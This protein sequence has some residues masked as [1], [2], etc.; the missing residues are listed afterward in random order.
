MTASFLLAAAAVSAAVLLIAPPMDVDAQAAPSSTV[1]LTRLPGDHAQP[2]A[3][4]ISIGT[5]PQSLNVIFTSAYASSWVTAKE[6]NGCARSTGY[7][8]NASSTHT[9]GTTTKRFDAEEMMEGLGHLQGVIAVDTVTIGGATDAAFPFTMVVNSTIPLDRYTAADGQLSLLMPKNY[10]LDTPE[11]IVPFLDHLKGGPTKYSLAFA[12]DLSSGNLTLNPTTAASNWI[13]TLDE[14]FATLL[15]LQT[16]S[17]AETTV[18]A[19]AIARLQN[20]DLT[21]FTFLLIEN[22]FG[23][24]PTAILKAMQRAIPGST[25]DAFPFPEAKTLTV[26]CGASGPPLYIKLN[27][28]VTLTIPSSAYVERYNATAC[29]VAFWSADDLTDGTIV[30]L[31]YTHLRQYTTLFDLET[32]RVAFVSSQSSS[33]AAAGFAGATQMRVAV[34]VAVVLAALLTAGELVL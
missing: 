11:P 21:P 22:F 25:L 8:A 7:S 28:A 1:K 32:N 34:A 12:P 4:T 16:V 20:E 26:A 33:A 31:G 10:K 24:V 19:Q 18:D 13:S 29:K 15:P 30:Y 27:E 23:R 2:F 17:F 6:C 3:G 9:D 5:P 14:G